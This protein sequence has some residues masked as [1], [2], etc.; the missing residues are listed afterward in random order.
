MVELLD[1]REFAY[2]DYDFDDFLPQLVEATVSYDGRIVGVPFDIPIFIMLFRRDILDDLG[3]AVPT[4]MPE[5]LD[6]VKVIDE[7]R[8]GSGVRGTAGQWKTGHSSLQCE[9]SAW[10]W[11][12]GGHHFGSDNRPDYVTDG[13]RRGL[14]YML[15]LGKHMSPE[16]SGWD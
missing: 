13:N 14:E 1:R 5:Y 9:A 7:S 15:E 11:A 2:P 8:R 3:L 12:H 6:V 10:M 16:S 4:T